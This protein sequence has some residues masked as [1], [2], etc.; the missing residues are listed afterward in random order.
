MTVKLAVIYYCCTR[1]TTDNRMDHDDSI[2]IG[3]DLHLFCPICMAI[4]LQNLTE[5]NKTKTK[6]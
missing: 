1:K 5:T 2:E 6:Q 4:A 3:N